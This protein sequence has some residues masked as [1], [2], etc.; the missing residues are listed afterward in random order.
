VSLRSSHTLRTSSAVENAITNSPVPVR[1]A[2]AVRPSP[3][4]RALSARRLMFR[5][6]VGRIR[7]D[8]DHVTIRR[9]ARSRLVLVRYWAE[10]P[11]PNRRPPLWKNRAPP[12]IR[13]TRTP[14]SVNRHR[15]PGAFSAM[16]YAVPALPTAQR[17]F[18]PSRSKD[19]FPPPLRLRWRPLSAR[20]NTCS[21]A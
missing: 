11:F 20:F 6:D 10:F 5:S 1:A 13:R 4:H 3:I 8:D 14:P 9:R 2:P 21:E 19:S 17:F 16:N 12:E 15:R 7:R 18:L